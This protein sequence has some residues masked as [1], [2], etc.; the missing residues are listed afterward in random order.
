MKKWIALVLAVLCAVTLIAC[1][2]ETNK[3]GDG[4][5]YAFVIDGV[6]VIPGND[7]KPVLE[8]LQ[9]RKLGESAKGSCLG[10]IDGEDVLYD[11]GNFVIKTFR[12][13]E[14]EEIRWVSLADDSVSTKKGI[15][16]GASVDAVKAAY[17]EPTQESDALLMYRCGETELRFTLRDG[18]VKGIEYTVTE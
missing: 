16:V 3:G 1:K 6:G 2:D 4:E 8:Q 17:G 11:Y 14:E 12:T 5:L 7:A 15:K 18:A 9:S 10:G 13:A